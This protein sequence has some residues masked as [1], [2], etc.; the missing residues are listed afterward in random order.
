MQ[1]IQLKASCRERFAP[2][3]EAIQKLLLDETKEPIIVALD[4]RCASGK[5]TLGFYLM[6]LF[7][8]NLFHMDDFF[9]QEHQRTEERLAEI[10]GNVDYERF[11]AEVLEKIQRGETVSY[12]RFDCKSMQIMEGVEIVSKRLNIIEGSYVEN[13]Y[14]GEVYDLKIF[15]DIGKE[16]QFQN[17]RERNGED[18]L[19]VFKERWI[20][21]EEAYFQKC[22]I[23]EK[24]DIVVEWRAIK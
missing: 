9:L 7:D 24:S 4:G 1:K 10:G 6:E 13:P 3:V 5:S 23:K 18:K 19:K 21:M 16:M 20:P 14:F 2:V 11:K 8:A 22:G 17:I 15:M 12:R